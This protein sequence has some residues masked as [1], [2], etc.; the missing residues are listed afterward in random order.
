M[1]YVILEK[2]MLNV[3]I[4]ESGFDS[5]RCPGCCMSLSCCENFLCGYP[6]YGVVFLTLCDTLWCMGFMLKKKKRKKKKKC[7]YNEETLECLCSG[8]LKAS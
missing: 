4:T 7:R 2:S 8:L 3:A 5:R 1:S 6:V